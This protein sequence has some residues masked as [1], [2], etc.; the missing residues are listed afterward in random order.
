MGSGLGSVPA[1]RL[2]AAIGA[3]LAAAKPA[4]FRVAARAVPLAEI[5]SA[6]ARADGDAR[7][8]FVP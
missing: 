1:P 3:V 5:E 4:G 2:F 6:W 7:V 8:V